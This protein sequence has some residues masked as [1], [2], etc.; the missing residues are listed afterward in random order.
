VKRYK[1]RAL[2]TLDRQPDGE[3]PI[4]VGR[5]QRFVLRSKHHET[6]DSQIFSALVTNYG[7][8]SLPMTPGHLMVT[9]TLMGDEPRQYFDIGDHFALWRG[10]DVGSGVVTRRLFIW[11]PCG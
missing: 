1:F 4:P 6:H 11:G 10:H 7:E 9:V 5:V 3:T 2:L 8:D